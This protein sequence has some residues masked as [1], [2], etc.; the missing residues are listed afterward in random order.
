V[1]G[2]GGAIISTTQFIFCLVMT[3]LLLLKLLGNIAQ[4]T[5]S[6]HNRLAADKEHLVTAIVV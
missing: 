1:H 3:L 6:V 2:Y 5:Y 4:C